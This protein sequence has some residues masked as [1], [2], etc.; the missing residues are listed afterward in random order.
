MTKLNPNS[1]NETPRG[2]EGVPVDAPGN[3]APAI[4]PHAVSRMSRA[5]D[6]DQT[7]AHSPEFTDQVPVQPSAS[8]PSAGSTAAAPA[9]GPG[10]RWAH[11]APG[12]G[13]PDDPTR[14]LDAAEMP[15]PE[16]NP[17]HDTAKD[18]SSPPRSAYD[19]ELREQPGSER[20]ARQPGPDDPGDGR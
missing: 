8:A 11:G 20:A 7:Q 18:P 1:M 10:Q 9:P 14:G 12:S 16:Q 17:A 5:E 3:T 15:R 6:D 13:G 19:G 2:P 4:S